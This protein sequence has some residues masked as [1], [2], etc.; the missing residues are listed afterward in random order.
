M[1]VVETAAASGG[2]TALRADGQ[3]VWLL[4]RPRSERIP[5]GVETIAV[6]VRRLAQPPRLER[7]VTRRATVNRIIALLDDLKTAQPGARSCPADSG[8]KVELSL[9]GA[10]AR[11]LAQAV[12]DPSG[13]GAVA[14]TIRG[15]SQPPLTG[16]PDLVAHLESLLGMRLT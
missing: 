7:T 14:L 6:L 5:N 3:S 2:G 10:R 15:Y 4:V 1:L 11:R 13:C 16:G 12:A 8:T 9:Y